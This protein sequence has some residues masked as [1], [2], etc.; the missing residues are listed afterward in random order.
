[1]VNIYGNSRYFKLRIYCWSIF[2]IKF[3]FTNKYLNWF[4]G[5]LEDQEQRMQSWNNLIKVDKKKY[6]FHVSNINWK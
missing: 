1:M 3:S 4:Y 6:T 5:I 2:R